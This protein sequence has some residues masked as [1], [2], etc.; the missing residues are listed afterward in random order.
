MRGGRPEG[1]SRSDAVLA[2][3]MRV[4]PEGS[5]IGRGGEL[6]GASRAARTLRKE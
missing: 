2:R 6:F 5:S 1:R 3:Q 4:A